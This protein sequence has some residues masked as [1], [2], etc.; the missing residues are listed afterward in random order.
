[1]LDEV[2]RLLQDRRIDKVALATGLSRE[3]IAAIRDGRNQNPTLTTLQRLMDYL[4][5]NSVR[6]G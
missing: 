2:R 4:R 3:T 5:E 1:M 6:A